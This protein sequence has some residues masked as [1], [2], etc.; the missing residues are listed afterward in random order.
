MLLQLYHSLGYHLEE[1]SVVL[2]AVP[3]A[4]DAEGRKSPEEVKAGCRHGVEE[5]G[6]A[7]ALKAGCSPKLCHQGMF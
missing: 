1:K 5:L 2:P 4:E 3:F 6:R 7:V